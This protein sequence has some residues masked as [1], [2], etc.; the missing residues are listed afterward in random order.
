M[1]TTICSAKI[2]Q[3][4]FK[5]HEVGHFGFSS[6]VV[7]TDGKTHGPPPGERLLLFCDVLWNEFWKEL[8]KPHP[9]WYPWASGGLPLRNCGEWEVTRT[10]TLL[11]LSLSFSLSCLI[12]YYTHAIAHIHQSDWERS[13]WRSGGCET[14]A[15]Y[16]YH[17]NLCAARVY[18]WERNKLH[19]K[20]FP[21]LL[22]KV[23]CRRCDF[24]EYFCH[25][26]FCVD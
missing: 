6:Y 14:A 3:T 26:L 23:S 16:S 1:L 18:L 2:F 19:F 21:L 22:V 24:L 13:S 25:S 7:E 4:T 11:P 17:G 10:Y 5:R 9:K 20:G 8:H 12:V 15:V